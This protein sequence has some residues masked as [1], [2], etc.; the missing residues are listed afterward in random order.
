MK[1][2][3]SFL[4]TGWAFPPSFK[5]GVNGT[6]MVSDGPDIQQS[7]A[8]LLSTT[9]G[10]RLMRPDYGC[11]LINHIFEPITLSMTTYITNLV[12]TAI[13]YHEPRV[14]LESLELKTTPEEGL[15]QLHLD[16]RIRSTNTRHN[17]VFPFYKDEGTELI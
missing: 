1:E 17:V 2:E 11:N 13:L 4:G 8:I 5:R 14:D 16:Y 15:L 6:L 9:L 7:L 10:E 12:R 3:R